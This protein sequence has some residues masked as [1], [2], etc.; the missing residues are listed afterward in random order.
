VARALQVAGIGFVVAE[1]DHAVFSDANAEGFLSVWG[2]IAQEAILHA[3]HVKDARVVVLTIPDQG[4]IRRRAQRARKMNPGVVLVAR[5]AH[6]QNVADLRAWGVNAT[7]QP[8][9]E[10][11][12]EMFRQALVSYSYDE[13]RASHLISGLRSDLYGETQ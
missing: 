13:V 6:E 7:V 2:D 5:A 12:I 10:G 9:F 4:T 3:A 1:W 11:G 8:E